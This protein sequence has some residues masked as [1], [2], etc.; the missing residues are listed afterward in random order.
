MMHMLVSPELNRG[1]LG[2]DG[3]PI[4][5]NYHHISKRAFSKSGSPPGDDF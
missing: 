2:L 4:W 1:L 3:Q 5:S